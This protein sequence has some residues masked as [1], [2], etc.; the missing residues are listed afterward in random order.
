MALLVTLAL[1]QPEAATATATATATASASASASAPAASDD[2]DAP[3]LVEMTPRNFDRVADG[4][5]VVVCAFVNPAL[6]RSGALHAVLH[7]LRAHFAA[8]PLKGPLPQVTGDV[9]YAKAFDEALS[10]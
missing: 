4:R 3:E 6:P 9:A 2:A 5:Q 7:E 8:L 1:S 10:D